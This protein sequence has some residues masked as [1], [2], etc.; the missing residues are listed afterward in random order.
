MATPK[1]SVDPVDAPRAGGREALR[2]ASLAT[3]LFVFWLVLSGYFTPF[4]LSAGIGCA[5]G[6]AWLARR[7]RIADQEAHPVR[8][9]WRTMLTYWPWLAKEIVKSA[10]QVTWAILHPR[11][12]IEP[13]VVR[14]RPSQRSDLA[15]VIHANSITLT[16][17]TIC[18]DATGE[19][20][21]VHALTR[22]TAQGVGAGSD[23]D[24][25]V[26]QLERQV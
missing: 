8:L 5:I 20:F 17:G 9:G 18:I 2:L 26:A 4:L 25:R 3:T 22:A 7:L 21:L 19:E 13:S 6:T 23:M 1:T 24:R 15:R 12:P 14:F 10:L 16:P 11:L